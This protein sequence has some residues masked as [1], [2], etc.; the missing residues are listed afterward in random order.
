MTAPV[1]AGAGGL[2]AQA[3]SYAV[4][5]VT[6]VTPDQLARPTPCRGWDLRMLLRHGCESLAALDEGFASGCVHLTAAD[7]GTQADCMNT[8]GPAELFVA[9]AGSLLGSWTAMSRP[10]AITVGGLPLAM[11]VVAAAAALEIAVHGWDVGQAAGSRLPIP[12]SLATSLLEVAPLLVA[13]SDRTE[14]FGPPV[15][16]GSKASASDRLTAF[17]GRPGPG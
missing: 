14:L 8:D 7:D 6:A 13:D 4:A 9:R 1:L 3:V 10:P 16:T 15:T 11:D 2:L 12:P 5:N 17:L